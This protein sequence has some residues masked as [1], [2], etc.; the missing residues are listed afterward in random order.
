V[1][2]AR[3]GGIVARRLIGDRW[4]SAAALAPQVRALIPGAG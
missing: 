2:L 1:E 3:R 4:G